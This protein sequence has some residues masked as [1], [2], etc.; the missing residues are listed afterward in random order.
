MKEKIFLTSIIAMGMFAPAFAE[1]SNTGTFPTDGLMQE[2][3][4]YTNAANSD[5]MDGVYE[6]NATVNAIAEYE[7]V[8]YQIAAGKYLPAGA[9]SVIDCDQSG[10]FCAGV[11][12]GVNYDANNNQG[13]TSCSDATNGAYTLSAGTGDSV[14]S[15]YRE[16]T[17]ADVAHSTGTMSGGYYYGDNN[18]CEPTSCENGWHV[19][20]GVPDLTTAIGTVAGASYGYVNNAGEQK[21]QAAALGI[22]D[23]NTWAVDYGTNGMLVGQGRCSTQAGDNNSQE[24]S[25]PTITSNLTDETGQEGAPFCYCNV[26]GYTPDG[27]TLQSVSS[28]WVFRSHTGDASHCASDCASVCASDM[29]STGYYYLAE[30][31]ALLGSVQSSPATC[32]AN[33]ITINW[34]DAAQTDI[35]ANNAG[36]ATYGEDIRTPVKAATKPG[37]T[38]RGWRFS[39]PE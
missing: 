26:T 5:N 34:S 33:T 19:K 27:G 13:L 7:N 15:C 25:N 24:W 38:F 30:R 18:Q 1:P 28:P 12:N 37:K 32:E 10:Y 36:T 39:K 9:E 8:L 20:A 35:D 4:T 23:K 14:N 31:A 2:D 17:N 16:C 6:N 11:Q 29:R 3:Y 21:Q 22:S